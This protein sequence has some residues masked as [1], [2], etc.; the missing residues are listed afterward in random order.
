MPFLA[1]FR[2]DKDRDRS[3]SKTPV[4][5]SPAPPSVS[6]RKSSSFSRAR[7]RPSF[8]SSR[9]CTSPP[10][11]LANISPSSDFDYVLPE[12]EI[13]SGPAPAEKV[14]EPVKPKRA[15][16]FGKRRGSASSGVII[17]SGTATPVPRPFSEALDSFMARKPDEDRDLDR[18]R[19]AEAPTSEP[20][21][22][23]NNNVNTP[24]TRQTTSIS[25]PTALE[26]L[27][28]D[29]DP[30]VPP[31]PRASVFGGYAYSE[32]DT[33]SRTQSLPD[34][35]RES[36]KQQQQQDEMVR[37]D[38]GHSRPTRPQVHPHQLARGKNKSVDLD[39]LLAKPVVPPAP[40]S[41][42][43]SAPVVKTKN[44]DA[45]KG[46]FGWRSKSSKEVPPAAAPEPIQ[47]ADPA[48]SSFS[49]KSF[50]HVGP[51]SSIPSSPVAQP[52]S[53]FGSS[54]NVNS[55][56]I[57]ANTSTTAVPASAASTVNTPPSSYGRASPRPVPGRTGTNRERVNSTGSEGVM[58]AGLFR[59]A[60]RRSNTNLVEEGGT[61]PRS[62]MA[63]GIR[64]REKRG[65]PT[66]AWADRDGDGSSVSGS[67]RPTRPP[68]TSRPLENGATSDRGDLGLGHRPQR[69]LGRSTSAMVGVLTDEP[70]SFASALSQLGEENP[71]ARSGLGQGAA[72]SD[73][74]NYGVRSDGALRSVSAAA[75]PTRPTAPSASTMPQPD[76]A[77]PRPGHQAGR[78]S[79]QS[80]NVRPEMRGVNARPMPQ[81][82]SP[83]VAS[84]PS[85]PSSG[86]SS[87][88][89]IPK[90]TAPGPQGI[91]SN[92]RP[93]P[94]TTQSAPGPQSPRRPGPQSARS[95]SP[96]KPRQSAPT[97]IGRSPIRTTIP[98]KTNDGPSIKPR[99][100]SP[101]KMPRP[102][103]P[104]HSARSG[105]SVSSSP[106]KSV[107][108]SPTKSNM[109]PGPSLPLKSSMRQPTSPTHSR[110]ASVD[111]F[112]GTA[113]SRSPAFEVVSRTKSPTPSAM[114]R[115][116]SPAPSAM[117]HAKSS[118]PTP[119]TGYVPP[120]RQSSLAAPVD[121][122]SDE[123]EPEEAD[124]GSEELGFGGKKEAKTIR[125]RGAGAPGS[126][127]AH[128][129]DGLSRER[130]IT[131]RTAGTGNG[132]ERASP[133]PA[134]QP[135]KPPVKHGVSLF[136]RPTPRF[137][138]S[139]SSSLSDRYNAP[140]APG[141]TRASHSTS[142]ISAA[143]TAR[144]AAT[145]AEANRK[146]SGHARGAS[147]GT[148]G[149]PSHVRAPAE[150]T[151]TDEDEDDKSESDS[152]DDA[153]LSVLAG[154]RRPGSSA[155]HVSTAAP[156]PPMPR[157]LGRPLVNMSGPNGVAPPR[158]PRRVPGVGVTRN[159]SLKGSRSVEDLGRM[160]MAPGSAIGGKARPGP[161]PFIASPPSSTGDSSSG[162]APLTPRDGSEAGRPGKSG[163][164]PAGDE[165]RRKERRR[166][167][168][169]ASVEL[170]NVI[171]GPGPVDDD[172][173]HTSAS[174]SQMGH[175]GMG[176]MGWNQPL[177]PNMTGFPSFPSS[178][179]MPFGPQFS[180]SMPF[181]PPPPPPG[182]SDAYLMAHQQA[183][184]MAKQAYL[185]AV[186]QQAVAM[187]TEQ[188]ERSSNAG[189]SVY[190]GSQMSG[191]SMMGGP[192]MGMY[193][194]SSYA[195][196]AYEGSV[197][198]GGGGW[199]SASAY[200]GGARS[201]YGGAAPPRN[202][203]RAHTATAEN[204]PPAHRDRTNP[205]PPSTWNTRRKPGV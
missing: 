203:A 97:A 96:T 131:Q 115:T 109:P 56:G 2:K 59:Q 144:N 41:E 124:S 125:G 185:S 31:P 141:R 112:R 9:S 44:K 177:F 101:I 171:N 75:V 16:P 89:S 100:S 60:A 102:P 83:S 151:D 158:P 193:A 175:G 172:D 197:I 5:L 61:S 190:G 90:A 11:Q 18:Q 181:I 85:P 154:P 118:G 152:E 162:K 55:A 103:S 147:T 116:K 21:I 179:S 117:S 63:M 38:H 6:S 174:H 28:S 126:S 33:P 45:S 80:I 183:V 48:D 53:A 195:A 187:A 4:P 164:G 198:G 114:T 196:S 84:R 135:P 66:R 82:S 157:S 166:S 73:Y 10:P 167:E 160:T 25:A 108:G 42:S 32:R 186:A 14:E 43:G 153:P 36:L 201:V 17:A 138:K 7:S 156:V 77:N 165:A 110:Y 121:S 57:S 129:H 79:L 26:D 143:A 176:M 30:L 54:T 68:R 72:R 67:E 137:D 161:R 159:S 180:Q 111:T 47:T 205:M 123:S 93:G 173:E 139:S 155:S 94:Q 130:T 119:R 191:M 169:K 81:Q 29:D 91:N 12:I 49:L 150:A 58:T 163:L 178:Q 194:G 24:N 20:I 13:E 146:V 122:D 8:A 51:A 106:T 76:G 64:D 199:G 23:K 37:S 133:T 78:P 148:A 92:S 200:G 127:P 62:S 192:M 120:P 39:S 189:G 95:N 3:R 15:L 35:D 134:D 104:A 128:G 107:S 136:D 142:A 188:W 65:P 71:L 27:D 70:S 69:S 182:A 19:D 140:S 87:Q 204:P 184:M 168:A 132:S 40:A 99:P 34:V 170:G 98:T 145:L 1:I 46:L 113:S 149:R 86:A 50:R 22:S 88:S 105:R 202:R 74:K 52:G